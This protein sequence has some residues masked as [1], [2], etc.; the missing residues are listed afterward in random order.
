MV[1]SSSTP[2]SSTFSYTTNVG[3]DDFSLT[4][5]TGTSYQPGN[6]PSTNFTI[7]STA[8]GATMFQLQI[9]GEI[10]RSLVHFT[11][12]VI[13]QRTVNVTITDGMV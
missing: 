6:P 5:I 11:T 4:H 1:T 3:V 13:I 9:H 10:L 8:E 12:P 7:N 2:P